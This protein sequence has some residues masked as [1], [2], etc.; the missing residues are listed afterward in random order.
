MKNKKKEKAKDKGNG[1]CGH[2]SLSLSSM[3]LRYMD[4]VQTL[5]NCERPQFLFPCIHSL[6]EDKGV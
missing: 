3:C 5:I 4:D 1:T 2:L 6:I